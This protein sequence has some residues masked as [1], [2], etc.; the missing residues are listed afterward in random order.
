MARSSAW[1]V[2]DAA[3]FD[4]MRETSAELIAR[5]MSLD[6]LENSSALEF[7]LEALLVNE[8]SLQV[9]GFDRKAVD[10]LAIR[11]AD[12]LSSLRDVR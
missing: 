1:R 9:D 7:R 2:N 11:F 3:A 12:R 6:R 4:E 8:E 5:L 10:A